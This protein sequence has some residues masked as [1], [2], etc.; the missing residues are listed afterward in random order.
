MLISPGPGPPSQTGKNQGEFAGATDEP[1]KRCWPV[2]VAVVGSASPIEPTVSKRE[3][4]MPYVKVGQE[5]S[6]P[7]GL[8][9]E[10]YWS[11]RP[12]IARR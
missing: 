7:I 2:A 8:Y 12:W 6:G 5:S 1:E 3:D 11:G 9:N 4:A 10:D